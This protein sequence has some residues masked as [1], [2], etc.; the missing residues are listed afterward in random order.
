MLG[1]AALARKRIGADPG[2]I[3]VAVA[4]EIVD[5]DL[6]VGKCFAEQSL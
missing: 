1:D 3:M 6:G 2:S 5:T 4:G